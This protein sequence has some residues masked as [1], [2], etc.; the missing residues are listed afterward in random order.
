MTTNIFFF[1][2]NFI[3]N[4]IFFSKNNITVIVAQDSLKP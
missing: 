1:L 3:F 4:L 2:N